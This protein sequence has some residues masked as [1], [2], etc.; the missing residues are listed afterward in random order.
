MNFLESA[1][2]Q[3]LQKQL[4][5]AALTHKVIANNIA[6]VNTPGFKK[7]SVRFLDE[8]KKALDPQTLPLRTAHP[9]H[10]PAPVPLAQVEPMVVKEEETTMG[11]N[12][13]NVDVEQEMV[14]LVANTLAYQAATRAIGDRL[15][16]L[17]YVIRGR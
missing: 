2:L 10:I 14:N 4:D 7:S 11:Y 5:A 12:Q 9:R 13:N 15:A 1:V 3:V 16:L 17:G 8:L 6:N